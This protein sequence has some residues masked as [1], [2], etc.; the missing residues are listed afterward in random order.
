MIKI[1]GT[2]NGEAFI[3]DKEDAVEVEKYNWQSLKNKHGNI[4]AIQRCKTINGNR[5]T[6]QLH[7]ELLGLKKGDKRQGNH[8]DKDPSNNTRKNLEIVTCS[9]NVRWQNKQRNNK[10]GYIGVCWDNKNEKWEVQITVNYKKQRIDRYDDIKEAAK[11][12]NEAAVKYHGR[13]AK[14]NII[15]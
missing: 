14:L 15:K 9:E 2:S 13:H 11:A 3:I 12:Y 6:L 8:I 4:V 10:S 1:V 5:E 7:R